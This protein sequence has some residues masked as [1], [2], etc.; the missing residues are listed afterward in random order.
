MFFANASRASC[1][2]YALGTESIINCGIFAESVSIKTEI[3][4]EKGGQTQ[5]EIEEHRQT[6]VQT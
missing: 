3:E 2:E 6:R 4:N 1:V 5:I